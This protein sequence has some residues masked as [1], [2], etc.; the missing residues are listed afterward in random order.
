MLR[1]M[2]YNFHW[3]C[4]FALPRKEKRFSRLSV[5][6]LDD[7]DLLIY[8]PIRGCAYT[9]FLWGIGA[10]N[11]KTLV[12]SSPNRDSGTMKG[13]RRIKGNRAP[14]RTVLYMAM[15][16]VIQC[17]S[18]MKQFYK[19]LVEQGKHTKVA[20]TACMRKMVTILNAM[21]RDN[22]EWQPVKLALQVL[23]FYHNRLLAFY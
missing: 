8:P 2:Q 10:T 1:T 12:R 22:C 3:P 23:I 20:P 19:K 5:S 7:H 16:S 9:A 6:I 18:V 4:T 14:I 13:K 15:L 17:S 11:T 21:V